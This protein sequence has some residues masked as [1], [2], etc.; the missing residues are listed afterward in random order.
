MVPAVL[1][2]L[3]LPVAGV[4]ALHLFLRGHNEPGGGF[5]AG[6]VVAIAFIAQYIVA[7]TRWVEDAHATCSPPRWIA[8][9]LLL[10]AGH[11]ARRAGLR[12]SVPHH[13]HR[14]RR[15]AAARRAAPAERAV[16]RP[17]RVRGGGRRDAAD[18]DGA[19]APVA[20]RAAAPRPAPAR[21]A[22]PKAPDG[23]RALARDRRARRLR[24]L[25][26]AAAAHLPGDHG[27]D[28]AVVRGQPV[29]L[30]HGQPVDRQ[31]ADR[32]RRRAARPA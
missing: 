29:H 20:A 21:R 3:L 10:A 28:A 17:R 15:A 6:L 31:G 25:A 27:A 23:S 30:Q 8:V 32:A 16:L 26:A 22:P 4:V 18:P 13:A 1:V 9:G 12:L 11:R 7:G 19:G 5:V 2:R 14:A 24:R